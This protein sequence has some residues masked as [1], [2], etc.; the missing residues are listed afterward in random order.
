[1]IQCHMTHLVPEANT[2]GIVMADAQ[3]GGQGAYM[4]LVNVNALAVAVAIVAPEVP[5]EPRFNVD[6]ALR[7]P[8]PT[9]SNNSCAF[10]P[11]LQ[12]Y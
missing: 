4:P 8:M 1:M 2:V 7:G 12:N 10:H 9:T 6:A 3:G 5:A 11:S